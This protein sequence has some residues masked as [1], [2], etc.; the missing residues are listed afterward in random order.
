VAHAC[1]PSCSGGRD[2]EDCGSKPARANTSWDP[3]SKN[4]ITERG[5]WSGSRCRHW[6]QAPVPK[7]KKKKNQQADAQS[8]RKMDGPELWTGSSTK[9]AILIAN[10]HMDSVQPQKLLKELEVW[11]KW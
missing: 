7:K 9:Q 6:V 1:N 2:Q 5:W 10:K 3:I 4:P 11:L 8:K